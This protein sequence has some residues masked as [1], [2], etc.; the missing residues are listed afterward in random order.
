MSF[1]VLL[2]PEEPSLLLEFS[3][4]S[5]WQFFLVFPTAALVFSGPRD[6]ERLWL[7]RK[8]GHESF[9]ESCCYPLRHRDGVLAPLDTIGEWVPTQS[10][11]SH[12]V[13]SQWPLSLYPAGW[14]HCHGE[15]RWDL[16]LWP[17]LSLQQPGRWDLPCHHR[18]LRW[19][20]EP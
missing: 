7:D 15:G 18:Q 14:G 20:V 12:R 19:R 5:L 6:P 4:L 9:L 11:L 8:P 1:H 17:D 13:A 3:L 2:L 16:S 10:E